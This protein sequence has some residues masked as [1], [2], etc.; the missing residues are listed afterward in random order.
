MSN[1]GKSL[2]P[3]GVPMQPVPLLLERSWSLS[4][5]VSCQHVNR[6]QR[7][8]LPQHTWSFA[9]VV[10]LWRTRAALTKQTRVWGRCPEV[11]GTVCLCA[12]RLRLSLWSNT[13]TIEESFVLCCFRQLITVPRRVCHIFCLECL[14]NPIENPQPSW[15]RSRTSL[16]LPVQFSCNSTWFWTNL[17]NIERCQVTTV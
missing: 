8:R 16:V 7:L 6:K 9:V 17:T 5:A 13:R 3:C 10:R 1:I 12:C 14:A 15:E 11:F 4:G 2:P